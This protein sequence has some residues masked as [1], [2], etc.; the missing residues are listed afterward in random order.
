MKSV[1]KYYEFQ[2]GEDS[3]WRNKLMTYIQHI[4]QSCR[5]E[6]NV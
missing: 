1:N 5:K 6:N 3:A 2:K 4:P